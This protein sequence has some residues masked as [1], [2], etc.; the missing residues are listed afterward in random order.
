[1]GIRDVC[2][3]GGGTPPLREDG[4]L[5]GFAGGVERG[6]EVVLHTSSV[7]NQRF[8]TASPQGEALGAGVDGRFL[9]CFAA[10]PHPSAAL[11]PNELWSD[12]HWRSTYLYSLRCDSLRAAPAGRLLACTPLRRQ[13]ATPSRGR[14]GA[15]PRQREA[16]GAEE[17]GTVAGAR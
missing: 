1:M 12:R 17:G 11:T 10:A 7:K 15:L 14:L 13:S 3:P 9:R 6:R 2:V 16:L 5:G 8:L 4:R